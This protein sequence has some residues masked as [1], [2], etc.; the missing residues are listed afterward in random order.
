[1]VI[2]GTP[3]GCFDTDLHN[4]GL[5]SLFVGGKRLLEI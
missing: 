3:L 5:N 1:M 4:G 2:D